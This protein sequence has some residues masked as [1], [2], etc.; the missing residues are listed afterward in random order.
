MATTFSHT[1]TWA[2]A[3]VRRDAAVVCDAPVALFV[4][5]VAFTAQLPLGVHAV[6]G[7]VALAVDVALTAV[8]R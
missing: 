8:R 4:E 7:I 6:L 1:G 2:V 5:V 3:T